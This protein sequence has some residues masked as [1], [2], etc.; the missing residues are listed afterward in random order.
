MLS[1]PDFSDVITRDTFK[2]IKKFLHL[3]DNNK[4]K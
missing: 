2:M 3:T 4:K 1:I